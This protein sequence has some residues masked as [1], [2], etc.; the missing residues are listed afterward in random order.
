[1]AFPPEVHSALLSSGPGP[2]PL[3]ASAGAWNALNATYTETAD[4]LTALLGSVQGGAWDGPTAETYVAAHTPYLA[5]LAQAGANSA[6]MAVQQETAAA[7]YTSALAAMPTLAELAA[8]HAT[9]AVLVA[10][11]FFGINTIPIA[12]NEA[13]YARMWVQAATTMSG[14]QAVSTGAVAATPT[15][16]AAPQIAN[17]K[18]KKGFPYPDPKTLSQDFADIVYAF[19][20]GLSYNVNGPYPASHLL[21]PTDLGQLIYLYADTVYNVI[22]G[23]GPKVLALLEN[24]AQIFTGPTLVLLLGFIEARIIDVIVTI[25]FFAEFPQ[26]LI[27]L[28]APV[29]ADLGAVAVAPVAAI[30]ALGAV[31]GSAGLAGLAAIPTGAEAIP[32]VVPPPPAPTVMSAPT[33]ASPAP[34]S[35]APAPPAAATPAA[36]AALPTPGAPPPP[37]GVPPAPPIGAENFGYLV[38]GIPAATTSS[39]RAKAKQKTP[40]SAAAPSATPAA[41]AQEKAQARRRRRAKAT[42]AGRG[43]EYMD[44]DDELDPA[45]A[46]ADHQTAASDQGAGTLG[47]TGA[48]PKDAGAEAAGLTALGGDSFGDSPRMPMMPST[49]EIDP[50]ADPGGGNDD[51]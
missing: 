45:G 28:L 44:L 36:A 46:R 26:Y 24:P 16:T 27:P 7:A 19:T 35:P 15:T 30:P 14:Y 31:G 29:I 43:Y 25:K 41:A 51:A 17:A 37:G 9:H 1:M 32:D 34:A 2:G 42:M 50:P 18:A 12:L 23:D 33:S 21:N 6:A 8:N 22:S 47:F 38:G 11:N 3:L 39:T 5:W 40:D 4:E 49:W 20:D 48:T 13:D 10:T